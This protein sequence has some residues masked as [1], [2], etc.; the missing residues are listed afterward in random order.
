MEGAIGEYDNT[1]KVEIEHKPGEA[2]AEFGQLAHGWKNNGSVP[3]ALPARR[4]FADGRDRPPRDTLRLEWQG[5]VFRPFRDQP[6]LLS[7][8]AAQMDLGAPDR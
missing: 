6:P 5:S 3:A 1:C 7:A 8:A 2:T 4:R